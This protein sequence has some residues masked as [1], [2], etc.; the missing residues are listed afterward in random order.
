MDFSRF[1]SDDLRFELLKIIQENIENMIAEDEDMW[2]TFAYRDLNDIGANCKDLMDY[3]NKD[4]KLLY[5][6]TL[7]LVCEAV[8]KRYISRFVSF[9]KEKI[10]FDPVSESSI[11]FLHHELG[12]S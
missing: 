12:G 10:K 6:F 8:P 9:V 2:K 11:D 3:Q 7:W 5:L 1:I 4:C